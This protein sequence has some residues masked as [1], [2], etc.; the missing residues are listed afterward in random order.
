MSINAQCQDCRHWRGG[1]Q[2]CDAFQGPHVD[3]DGSL[4]DGLEIP[5]EIWIGDIDH[6]LPYE[7]DNGIRFE[8]EPEYAD[9]WAAIPVGLG[10]THKEGTSEERI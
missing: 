8:P 3:D 2:V 6:R 9:I 1:N 7:G 10:D 4:V 5:F